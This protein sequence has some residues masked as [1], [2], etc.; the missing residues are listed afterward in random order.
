[1][2]FLTQALLCR[3]GGLGEPQAWLGRELSAHSVLA[4]WQAGALEEGHYL[5]EPSGK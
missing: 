4:P 2:V 3:R 5:Q 1:M